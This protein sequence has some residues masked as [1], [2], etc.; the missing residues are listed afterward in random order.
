MAYG[1]E[2]TVDGYVDI[3]FVGLALA[4]HEMGALHT[5]LSEEADGVVLEQ[6]LDVLTLFDTLLHHL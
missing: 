6:D 3:L 1:E 5:V 4:L 2:E